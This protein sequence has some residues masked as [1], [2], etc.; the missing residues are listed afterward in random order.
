MN[1]PNQIYL[2]QIIPNQIIGGDAFELLPKIKDDSIDLIVC[3]GP[4][5]VTD[6]KWDKISDIQQ[7]NLKLITIFSQKLKKGGSLY[8]FGKPNCIDFIDYRSYLNLQ[9]KIVW[10]QPSRLAQGRI[11][12]T[13]N[14]DIVCYFTKGKKA[15]TFNLDKVRVPQLVELAHRQRCER[16]PSVLKGKYG[17]TKFHKDGKNPGDVWGDIKQLTYKSK[18]LVSRDALNTIQKPL[19]LIERLLLASSNEGDVVLDPF[20]G[21]GTVPLACEIHKRDFYAFEFNKEFVKIAKERIS[22]WEKEKVDSLMGLDKKRENI[23]KLL[24]A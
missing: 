15:N 3:D 21:V 8:L 17:K 11:N 16:V 19:K 14:Y 23:S 9:A 22:N 10:Y 20:C 4:F 2:N 12:W 18:E 7:F 6:Q 1:S 5:G 13:N 24:Y